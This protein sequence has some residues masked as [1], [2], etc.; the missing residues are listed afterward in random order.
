MP[1]EYSKDNPK[2][3]VELSMDEAC[4]LISIGELMVDAPM[5]TPTGVKAM[6]EILNRISDEINKNKPPADPASN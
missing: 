2:L 4:L 6:H 1:E 3:T 5:L